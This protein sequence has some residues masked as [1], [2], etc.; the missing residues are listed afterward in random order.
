MKTANRTIGRLIAGCVFACYLTSKLHA[1]PI[2]PDPGTNS[3]SHG[4]NTFDYGAYYSN[5]L[6]SVSDWLH[7]TIT[8]ADGTPADSMQDLMDLQ[9]TTFSSSGVF[10]WQASA[11][12]AAW[13]WATIYGL[14]TEL[15]PESGLNAI[16]ISQENGVPNY[17]APCD[18]ASDI[19]INTTNVWPGGSAGFTL[20]GTNTII[21]QWDLG[22]PLLTHAELTNRVTE[23]DGYTNLAD[24]STAVAGMLAA[25]GVVPVYSNTV[26]LGYVL[27]GTAYSANV[28]AWTFANGD[29]AQMTASVGTNH[30][31]LSNHSYE[32]VG[33]WYYAGT[34]TWIWYGYW[35]IGS[36]DARFGNYTTN[37]ASYDAIS[38]GAP[39][40]LQV[41]AAGN[42]QNY[43][44]PVQPT[45]HYE[46]T[47]SVSPTF[48]IR[49]LPKTPYLS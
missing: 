36:Q 34:A 44:P 17:L 48:Y 8:N 22:S 11:Q 15:T 14:Q 38:V 47:L 35:Q 12:D 28:Q 30:M 20:T 1:Q 26:L 31:R 29:T 21:S 7:D 2:P 19:T 23:M 13:S 4:T 6:A 46:I 45:N 25:A 32:L 37:T 49:E 41:W 3:F 18:V 33:G 5:N 27:K 10:D 43:A 42:E 16:L 24:H 39:T 9:A 40:Y